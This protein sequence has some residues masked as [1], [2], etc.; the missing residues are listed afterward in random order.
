M[1]VDLSIITPCEDPLFFYGCPFHL[2]GMDG[3][4]LCHGIIVKYFSLAA[5][6][7]SCSEGSSGYTPSRLLFGY[8][9]SRFLVDCHYWVIQRAA[10]LWVSHAIQYQVIMIKERKA[11]LIICKVIPAG[12]NEILPIVEVTGSLQL[13]SCFLRRAE[14]VSV[15]VLKVWWGGRD[16]R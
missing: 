3:A 10:G 1:N 14:V 5:S 15:W 16:K 12:G 4:S 6:G 8:I 13:V 9:P 7:V 11:L 2:S